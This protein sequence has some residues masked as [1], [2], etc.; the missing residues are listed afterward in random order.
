MNYSG[1]LLS[2]LPIIHFR[3]SFSA[4]WLFDWS[5]AA[6]WA[7]LLTTAYHTAKGQKMMRVEMV[8]VI[9]NSGFNAFV[10]PRAKKLIILSSCILP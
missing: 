4:D 3:W 2:F 1:F 6:K 5:L 9:Q 7:R 10:Y 8:G